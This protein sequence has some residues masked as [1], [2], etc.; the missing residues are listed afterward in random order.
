VPIHYSDSDLALLQGSMVL[1]KIADRRDSLRAEFVEL[2]RHLGAD[3]FG[4]TPLEIAFEHGHWPA[5]SLLVQHHP[6]SRIR[7]AA[8]RV[9]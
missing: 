2:Q 6:R 8:P 1:S 3:L 7:L 5:A 9:L 4:R